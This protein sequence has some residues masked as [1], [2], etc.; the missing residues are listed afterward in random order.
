MWKIRQECGQRSKS[1]NQIVAKCWPLICQGPKH[2]REDYLRWYLEVAE[3]GIFL[4]VTFQD[5]QHSICHIA[6]KKTSVGWLTPCSEVS[7][8]RGWWRGRWW[9]GQSWGGQRGARQRFSN[10]RSGTWFRKIARL[11]EA[12][13]LF[14]LQIHFG[15]FLGWEDE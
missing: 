2:G 11:L 8:A 7:W 12:R 9:W 5:M 4:I 3:T 10:A 15:L 6:T 14:W 13:F 1:C